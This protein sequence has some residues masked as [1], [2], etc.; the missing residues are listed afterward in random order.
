MF[1]GLVE[2]VGTVALRKGAAMAVTSGGA[3]PK[4][5]DSIAV[6]GVCLTVV[7][8]RGRGKARDLYFDLSE[9]TLAKTT[10]CRLERGAR[11]NVERSLTLSKGLGGHIVQGHV[12]GVGRVSRI[13]PQGEMKT[14]WFQAPREVMDYVVSK[15]S[16]TVDGVSLTAAAV[17][18]DK[19]SVALIPYTLEHTTIGALREGNDVNL[20]ADVI[21]KYVAKYMRKR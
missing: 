17:K 5:G 20:E 15:G 18:G 3:A 8:A 9:E 16:I 19:F 2:E 4:K 7:N 1:S 21:G 6:N 14:I 11:V 13:V 12:D 10:L